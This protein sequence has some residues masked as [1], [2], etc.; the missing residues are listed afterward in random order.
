MCAEQL[1][2]KAV[3]PVVE[4]PEHDSWAIKL[5]VLQDLWADQLSGLLSAFEKTGAQMNVENMKRS[6]R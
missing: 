4:I 1:R 6:F 2:S 3:R 5:S